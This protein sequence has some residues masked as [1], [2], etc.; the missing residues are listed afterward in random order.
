[1]AARRH[2][3]RGACSDD[4]RHKEDNDQLHEGAVHVRNARIAAFSKTYLT[5]LCLTGDYRCVQRG[6]EIPAF[7]HDPLKSQVI[8]IPRV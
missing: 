6:G 2:R 1:M 5:A 8:L 7:A 4:E 3:R